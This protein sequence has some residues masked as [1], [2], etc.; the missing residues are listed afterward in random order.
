MKV[1][2]KREINV[3]NPNLDIRSLPKSSRLFAGIKVSWHTTKIYQKIHQKEMEK[4]YKL[5]MA[6]I[7]KVKE[8]LL[9][10][11]YG[12]LVN[13][14]SMSKRKL[15]AGK[16]YVKVDSVFSDCIDEALSH[17]DFIS[18]NIKRVNENPDIRKAFPN[19]PLIFECSKKVLEETD[20]NLRG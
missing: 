3:D 13:N 5:R 16:I 14:T 7:D 10:V 1:K 2:V 11:L 18:F 15:N 9:S 19:M 17:K 6:M 8:M 20:S 12:E 4:E